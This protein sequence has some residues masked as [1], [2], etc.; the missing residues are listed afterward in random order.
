VHIS[1][2]VLS[3]PVL[4]SGAAFAAAG[5]V[6]GLRK[7]DYEKLPEVAALSSVFFVASLIHVPIGPSAVHLI[8]PGVCGVL[9]GWMAFPAIFIGLTLQA[10]LF[11]YGGLTV[12]GIN[13]FVM[14]FP[15]TLV[16]I[17]LRR[18]ANSEKTR[19]RFTAQFLC[20]ALSVL[21]SGV[22]VGLA[23]V[24]TNKA[25]EWAALT[26]V[27]AHGPVMLVEG[28]ITVFIL[29]FLRKVRPE[30]IPANGLRTG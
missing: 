4:A 30:M 8:L 23:L 6:I 11:Q 5:V 10:V 3:A 27:L 25:F 16:G 7:M 20:G 1:E 24:L 9:L 28:M 21:F 19:I 12:L 17:G 22:L 13:T 2:G 18:A 26:V 15:A 14:A 29:E